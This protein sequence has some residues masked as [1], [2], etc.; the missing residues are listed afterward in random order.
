MSDDPKTEL[1][2]DLDQLFDELI[3]FQQRKVFAE[4]RRRNQQLTED[5][6]QQPHDFPE[7]GEDA[8]WSYEDGLLAGYR[9][10][11][12]AVRARLLREQT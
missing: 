12:M 10:A 6:I 1:L 7:I 4:A 11:H 8:A 5:D 3:A 9:A 2:A